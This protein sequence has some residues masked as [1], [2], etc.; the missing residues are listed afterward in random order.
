MR[1]QRDVMFT[2]V[3]RFIW[4]CYDGLIPDGLVI[5]HCNVIRDDSRLCNLQLVTKQENCKKSAKNR[6]YGFA[7]NNYQNKRPVK[8][9]NEEHYFPSL[10][11]VEKNLGVNC[12]ILKM[13]CEGLNCCKSGRSK[14]DDYWD[15]SEYLN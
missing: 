1:D 9:I 4:E 3:H 13:V 8:A 10:Y 2:D 14:V 7:K 5:D 15:R 6:D 11:S 12:G